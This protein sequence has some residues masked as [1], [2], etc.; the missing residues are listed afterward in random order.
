MMRGHCG[1]ACSFGVV[2]ALL[3]IVTPEALAQTATETPSP[4]NARKVLI[5][6]FLMLGPIKILVPFVNMTRGAD[7]ALRRSLAS[8]PQRWGWLGCSGAA[9]WKTSTS[10]CPSWP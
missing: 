4:I 1:L 10:R 9:C 5:M 3:L 8:P 2:A 7:A 6:L